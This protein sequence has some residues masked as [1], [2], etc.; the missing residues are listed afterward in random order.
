MT[1][2]LSMQP[3]AADYR[4]GLMLLFEQRFSRLLKETGIYD[5]IY[6]YLSNHYF[7]CGRVERFRWH[8]LGFTTEIIAC[9]L[10]VENAAFKDGGVSAT[11]YAYQFLQQC[12]THYRSC[13]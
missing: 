9:F 5:H 2:R 11:C 3:P 8:Q 10:T 1:D 12:I 4:N 13:R 6:A 7:D